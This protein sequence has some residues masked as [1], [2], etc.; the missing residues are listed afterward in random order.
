VGGVS[1]WVR[2]RV[3][4]FYLPSPSPTHPHPQ[5][6]PYGYLMQISHRQQV[7]HEVNSAL[8]T[9]QNKQS[10]SDLSM[11]VKMVNYM[12]DKLD[13]KSLRYPKLIDIPTRKLE[14]SL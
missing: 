2:V 12:Q 9:H 5:E 8:L 6:S 13:Q 10:E 1:V 11:L 3:R 4:V 7:A 14:D